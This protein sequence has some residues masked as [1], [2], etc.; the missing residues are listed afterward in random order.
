MPPPSLTEII[1]LLI[2]A[3]ILIIWA[4]VRPVSVRKETFGSDWAASFWGPMLQ[5]RYGWKYSSGIATTAARP[6]PTPVYEARLN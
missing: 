2:I 6:E 3:P 1:I 4:F 5:P